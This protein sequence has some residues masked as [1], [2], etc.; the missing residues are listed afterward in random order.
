MLYYLQDESMKLSELR[1][2][3]TDMQNYSKQ[4]LEGLIRQRF[5]ASL[6]LVVIIIHFV[7]GSFYGY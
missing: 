6:V 7:W 1:K 5:F 3:T 2:L 4:K